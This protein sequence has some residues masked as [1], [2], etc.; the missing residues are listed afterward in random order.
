[1]G[2]IQAAIGAIGGTLA[3]QWKDFYTV[4]QGVSATAAV[5]PAVK[6]GQNA[7][8]G[9]NTKGSE[10]IIT[11][12]STIV[13]PEGFGLVTFENG[14]ITG[15]VA[16]PGGYVF[17]S[18][19]LNAQS[20][21]SGGGL[22][23]ALIQQS[24]ER[25]KYGGMPGSQQAAFYVNLKEIPNNRFGTQAEI[26]WDDAYLQTQVGAITRGSYSLRIVDPLLFIRGFVPADYINA[27]STRAF[28]FADM[29]NPAGSQLF[30]EVVASLSSAFSK[31][32]N[33]PDK[34]NRITRIQQDATG[35]AASLWAAVD[36]DYHWQSDRGLMIVKAALMAIEYDEDTKALLSDV[37]KADALAGQRGNSFMQQSVA[38]G[39]EAAGSNPGGGAATMGIMGF[40]AGQAGQVVQGLTQP[41]AP[42]PAAPPA[43]PAP[44]PVTPPAPAPGAPTPADPYAELTKLKG[45]LDAGVITQED[46]DK[47]KN[48]LLGL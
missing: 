15:F 23:T 39:M 3:D 19:D 47:K 33:D 24:W 2:F 10:N 35:F 38:R 42:A 40:A 26:Y 12:G 44:A 11:N 41:V 28:D 7:G 8:R 21:F 27:G 32:T 34:G 31:Y 5:V 30:T 18:T 17:T 37:R 4:P 48:Q 36:E 22:D 14:A 9:S 45:L 43:P 1:M 20:F 29:D 13:I 46:F 6:Q 25:F 16:Q